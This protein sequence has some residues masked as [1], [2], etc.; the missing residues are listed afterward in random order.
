[1]HDFDTQKDGL[2][3]NAVFSMS[4]KKILSPAHRTSFWELQRRQSGRV[5]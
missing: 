3:V 5:S 4:A 1:M 2:F